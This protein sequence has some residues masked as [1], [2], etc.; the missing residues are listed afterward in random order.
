M[1]LIAVFQ[2]AVVTKCNESLNCC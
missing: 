2:I 1:Q